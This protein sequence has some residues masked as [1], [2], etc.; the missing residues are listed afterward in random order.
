MMDSLILKDLN[1]EQKAAVLHTE[2]PLIVHGIPGCGKS[3]VI[4]HRI[5]WLIKEKGVDPDRILGV[6]FTNQAADVMKE[7]V[8]RLCGKGAR[9]STFHSFCARILRQE[10]DPDFS[11]YDENDSR[12][13]I[14]RV[15]KDLG[16]EV[17]VPWR[18]VKEMVSRTKQKLVAPAGSEEYTQIYAEYQQELARQNALDF[19]DLLVKAV[20]I[21]RDNKEVR[22]RLA[23]HYRY[24]MVDE[25][26]DANKAEYELIRF[27]GGTYRNVC[28][29][30]DQDQSIYRFRGAGDPEL[31]D[32]F[33]RLYPD[34]T[35]I[36]LKMNYR[37]NQPI[38]DAA[39]R[40]IDHN[41]GREK[42][43]MISY[44]GPG[45]YPE[46]IV[47]ENYRDEANYV[48]LGLKLYHM[49]SGFRWRE[50]AI[51]YRTNAQSRELERALRELNVPYEMADTI[52][53]YM[54]KEVRDTI[55]YLRLLC[56]F[57]DEAALRRIVNRP[58]RRIGKSAIAKAEAVAREEQCS[59][60][61]AL[62]Q[63]GGAGAKFCAVI[64][65]E[66]KKMKDRHM[67]KTAECILKETG[68]LNWL[69]KDGTEEGQQRLDNIGELLNEIASSEMEDQHLD[70]WLRRM[71]LLSTTDTWDYNTD[72]VVMM[73][74]HSAKGLEFPIV[75]VV[76]A[77]EGMLPHARSTTPEDIEEERR[78]CYVGATRAKKIL[79]FTLAKARQVWGRWVENKPSRF[80]K[81]MGF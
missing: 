72:R 11:I 5:A 65:E 30:L 25:A 15:M 61:D 46:M 59:L 70:I 3:R 41:T 60:F 4:T 28:I 55:A 27:L 31:L 56:N 18:E 66:Q 23:G 34:R 45:K 58:P 10:Y 19:D 35:E 32:N 37:S 40:L 69:K 51:L 33:R 24:I 67:L 53:F 44:R 50:M 76:G 38:L 13:L 8:Y 39:K 52:S 9:L 79:F 64:I 47:V 1:D 22:E 78:L 29:V 68:Y 54:R 48:G 2:G 7:R 42:K 16:L 63:L 21:L 71:A 49:K 77:E 74:L 81:E 43:E 20:E 75:Y 17:A 80:L 36:F 26:H 62:Y 73:T 14:K 57:K 12:N 6:T